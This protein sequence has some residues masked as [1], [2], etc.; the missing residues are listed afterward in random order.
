[1]FKILLILFMI[2]YVAYKMSNKILGMVLRRATQQQRGWHQA[3]NHQNNESNQQFRK[4]PSGQIKVDYVPKKNQ[5]DK[6]L[7][8]FKGGEYIDFKEID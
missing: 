3:Y 6:D 2:F 7:E 4:K 8:N 5:Q 1:M